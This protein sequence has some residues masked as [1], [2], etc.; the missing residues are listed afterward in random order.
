MTPE[1]PW[2]TTTLA[3]KASKV[4]LE[5]I[6]LPICGTVGSIIILVMLGSV[7]YIYIKVK[8]LRQKRLLDNR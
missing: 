4:A 1:S 6:I 7:L 8:K 5:A 2:L 3:S